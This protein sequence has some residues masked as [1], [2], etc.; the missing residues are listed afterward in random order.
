MGEVDDDFS[1]EPPAVGSPEK[2]FDLNSTLSSLGETPINLHSLAP[3]SK[4]MKGQEKLASATVTLKR[5]LETA[6]DIS[7]DSP[8]SDLDS[9]D[10]QFFRNM[11][12][13]VK[14]K[15]N[16]SESYQERVQILT[17]S[18]F[19][20]ERTMN[21]FETTNYLV[22]KSRAV[23]KEKGILGLCDKKQGKVLSNELKEEIA[24]FY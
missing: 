22:K 10:L 17:L 7:L 19:T 12:G 13:E 3:S 1:V 15:F 14:E 9:S 18:P 8:E 24:Q 4:R 11:F 20:I 2:Y 5:Q 6:Y 16:K 21:E 23:K